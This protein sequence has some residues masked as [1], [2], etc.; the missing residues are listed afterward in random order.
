MSV[1][2]VQD[3]QIQALVEAHFLETRLLQAHIERLRAVLREHGIPLPE[4]D[5]LLGAS[6]GEH[7]EACKAVVR[8][9]Y[10]LLPALERLRTMVGSSMELIDGERWGK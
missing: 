8:G 7:L 6:D 4:E 5:P 3:A 9:A 1:A 2:A 10:E